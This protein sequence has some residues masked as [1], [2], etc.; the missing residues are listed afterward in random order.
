MVERPT[1][2]I[3]DLQY[4]LA[5]GLGI[6]PEGRQA[7]SIPILPMDESWHAMSGRHDDDADFR[8]TVFRFN[9]GLAERYKLKHQSLGLS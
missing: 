1:R 3:E 7:K 9:I 8:S 5:I 4:M 2:S 6:D